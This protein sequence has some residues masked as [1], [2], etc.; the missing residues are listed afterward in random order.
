MRWAR[1]FVVVIVLL[2]AAAF[3][4]ARV[5]LKDFDA[6]LL[7]AVCSAC[8][9]LYAAWH[10]NWRRPRPVLVPVVIT[11]HAML[12]KGELLFHNDGALPTIVRVVSVESESGID[13]EYDI[14]GG[15]FP[16][17]GY[18]FVRIP[19]TL[20]S[21]DPLAADRIAV[22]FVFYRGARQVQ[23]KA[24]LVWEG[25]VDVESKGARAQ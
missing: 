14:S 19:I 11:H 10:L 3:V 9:A 7:L 6:E 21:G 5:F 15:A 8:V 23:M 20:T 12:N 25:P 18:R 17:A 1:I 13:R 24:R 4:C 2:L 16:I 22:T